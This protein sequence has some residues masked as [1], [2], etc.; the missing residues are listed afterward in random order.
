MV[1]S[2]VVRVT[3]DTF[4]PKGSRGT[5]DHTYHRDVNPLCLRGSSLKSRVSLF[6]NSLEGV[7][8][9]RTPYLRQ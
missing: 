1:K 7:K 9:V 5:S 8:V 2:P 3:P 6:L 4:T